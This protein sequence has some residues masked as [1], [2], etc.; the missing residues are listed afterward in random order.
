MKITLK[1]SSVKQYDS[2]MTAAD[3]AK[4]ISMGL[5]RNACACN[6]L[7][8]TS[9]KHTQHYQIH[10]FQQIFREKADLYEQWCP[11]FLFLQALDNDLNLVNVI[12]KIGEL[13]AEKDF[14]LK[15]MASSIPVSYTHLWGACSSRIRCSYHRI[16]ALC[17]HACC[18]IRRCLL[19]M[20]H[21]RW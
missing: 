1:D 19:L 5:Y 2:A 3:I 13:M 11:Y 9:Q 16:Y 15:D 7:L 21:N 4:D 8:Y 12:T 18:K 10:C 20:S 14:P 6:C 17:P